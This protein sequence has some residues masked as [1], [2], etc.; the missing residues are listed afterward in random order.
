MKTGPAA[1]LDARDAE[2]LRDLRSRLNR[3]PPSAAAREVLAS[4]FFKACARVG[5]EADASVLAL[6]ALR[7]DEPDTFRKALADGALQAVLTR[8]LVLAGREQG[9]LA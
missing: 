6:T 9:E 2:L 8:R 4:A 3:L 1:A 5:L 7:R